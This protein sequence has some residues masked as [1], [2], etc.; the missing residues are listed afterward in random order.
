ML[1]AW[2]LRVAGLFGRELRDGELSAEM[3]SHLEL[4]FEDNLRRGMSPA[5]ARREAIMKLGG[6]EQTKESYRER[7]GLPLLEV[8]FQDLRFG[9]RTLRKNPG[10]TLVAVLTL[11]L[12][13]AANATV[14]S[15]VSAVLYK[16]PPVYDSDR[17]L[18]VYGTAAARGFGTSLN[19]VSAPN[20]FAWKRENRVFSDLAALEP[21]VSVS[22]T[23]RDEPERISVN[24]ATSNYFS[25]IG[26]APV[27]GRA[28]ANGDDQA[29]HD[30]V[31]LLDYR[32][33]ERKF[34]SDPNI[35]GKTIRLNGEEH[36]V[37]GVLP[38][39]F[40]IMSFRSQVWLPLVLDESQQSAAA[41]QTRTLYL[42]ARSK[43]GVTLDQAQSNLRTLGSLAVQLFPDTEAGWDTN[44]LTLQEYVIHD[45]NA[46]AGFVILLSAVGFVLLIACANIAGL[47][48]AR[49]ASRGKEMAI[50][51]AIGAGRARV[52]RQLMTEA[53]LIALLG[54]VAGLGLA[55]GGTQLLHQV[56]S[57]NEAIKMLEMQ[58]DWRVLSFTSAIAVL[59][60][61]LFGL[62]PALRAWAVDVF[63]TLKNDSSKVSAGKEKSRGRGLLVAAEVAMGVIL[64][65]GAGILIKGFLEGLHR[66]L[67][68]QPQHLLTAQ[69]S[70]PES[71]YKEPAKQI[72]F[73]RELAARLEAMPGATSAAIT[74]NL[75]AAG[76]DFVSFLLKGQENLS[77]TDR[78]RAR[79]YV[80][81]S[82]YFE[83]IQ[84][85]VIAGR[86][87]RESDSANSQPV[88][89]VT[90][91]FVAR[92]FSR[93]DALGKQ[94][95]IDSSD[96][97]R[98]QWRQIVGIVHDVKSWPLNYRDDPEIYEP[99][100]QHPA[101][102]MSVVVRAVNDANS[103]APGLREAV[104]SLDRDQP[105]GTVIS[106]PDL[107]ANE[108]A[109]DLIF[110]EL[111]T[112]FAALALVLAGIG[113]YGLVAFTVGQRSQEIG[114]RVAL[115][116]EKKN[117]LRMVL[118]DGL[119]LAAIGAAIGML[120]AFPLPRLFEAAFYNF[121]V[122]GGW[123]FVIVP[124]LIGAVALLACYIPA[125][126]ASRIDPMVALRYE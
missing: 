33:W 18:V 17:V 103:L 110:S 34:G 87:F 8:F 99:V 115:G 42:F 117:I 27:L 68:F 7:R 80:V 1:R 50:R 60:A 72:E 107:L 67:G 109:P 111:M 101:A 86:V 88:A 28:F 96:A 43:P 93:G 104:W 78:S 49:A 46:N 100:S 12:G 84:A 45:F 32:F 4:H 64:L 5:E 54:T 63:P 95:R 85:S 57:F 92:F 94:I 58:I 11:A 3:E 59:S 35:V 13:I 89:V 61:V 106:M 119:R 69:I 98:T 120:G 108:T 75:P 102:E 26:V 2:F 105:I 116:A 70:L 76:A 113:I 77:P 112:V 82:H 10:F 38:R 122:S 56:L 31:V 15:F 16:R 52:L 81:S 25:V 36:T 6:V 74:S 44:C 29:G 47:L 53:L 83:T 123:L 126:R 14:F 24:R 91:E 65:T 90:E 51:I 66:S 37:I 19:P 20:Y 121:H 23:G 73:Y 39:P 124:A 118:L 55:L 30:R 114:I 40:Q 21:Y 9:A 22:L 62:A 48:L 97:I 125:R 71:H 41:R 79:Y